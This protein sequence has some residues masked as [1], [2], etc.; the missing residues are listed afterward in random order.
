LVIDW[1]NPDDNL[2]PIFKTVKSKGKT[3]QFSI[4]TPAVAGYYELA[5]YVSRT[6]SGGNAITLTKQ[7]LVGKLVSIVGKLAT[8]SVF[9]AKNPTVS[10]SG[11]RTSGSLAVASKSFA[12]VLKKNGVVVKTAAGT[13]GSSGN[14]KL[15]STGSL[16]AETYTSS[17]SIAAGSVYSAATTST[18]SFTLG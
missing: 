11:S 10:V 6:C 5:S 14:Y 3:A 4:Q 15:N 16:T 12:A 18:S 13:T 7:I 2:E 1:T 17:V 9:V 8:T